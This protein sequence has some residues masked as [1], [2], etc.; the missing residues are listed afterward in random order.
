MSFISARSSDLD[1][2]YGVRIVFLATV[3]N[4]CIFP[5]VVILVVCLRRTS[6]HSLLSWPFR[7]NA[8][9]GLLS[10]VFGDVPPDQFI[11]QFGQKTLVA[12]DMP[13]LNLDFLVLS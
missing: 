9:H 2:R 5:V 10:S 13:Y 1:S 7:P 4:N 6:K 12:D 3:R 11:F 8:H